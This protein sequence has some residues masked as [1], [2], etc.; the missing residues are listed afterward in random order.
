MCQRSVPSTVVEGHQRRLFGRAPR[1]RRLI[2]G[3]RSMISDT[4]RMIPMLKEGRLGVRVYGQGSR[5]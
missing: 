2:T 3:G 5:V 4:V 1:K